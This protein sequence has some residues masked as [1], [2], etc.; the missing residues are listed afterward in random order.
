M[1]V[2]RSFKL[3]AS[4]RLRWAPAAR[5]EPSRPRIPL[6]IKGMVVGSVAEAMLEQWID[7][8]VASDWRLS[9]AGGRTVHLPSDPTPSLTELRQHLHSEGQIAWPQAERLPLLDEHGGVH[10]VVHRDLVRWL[11]VRTHSVHLIGWQGDACWV[12]ERAEHKAEDPARLDTLVGGTVASDE[13]TSATLERET[14][15]EAGLSLREL[16]RLT[17]FGQIH[18]CYPTVGHEDGAYTVETVHCLSA[19]LSPGVRP[20]NQ[21][22]EVAN[23]LLLNPEQLNHA[24][25]VERFTLAATGVFCRVT[26]SPAT[27]ERFKW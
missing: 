5:R 25:M 20:I 21:D 19:Q 12:Q 9:Q 23:F 13:D 7:V 15:E 10:G 22:G 24:L 18:L 1:V 3:D 4:C 2:P 11:G 8:G 6:L 16:T 17:S 26:Q 27:T 14:W